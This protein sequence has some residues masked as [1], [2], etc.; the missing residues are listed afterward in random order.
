M[1]R[2]LPLL[3]LLMASP[4]DPPPPVPIRE[5]AVVAF[6]V[7]TFEFRLADVSAPVLVTVRTTPSAP[8]G[9]AEI[10]GL[11]ISLDKASISVGHE[12]LSDI[13]DPDL[14]RLSAT[15]VVT[16]ERTVIV[17]YLLDDAAGCAKRAAPA[18]GVV[19][20]DWTVGEGVRKIDQRRRK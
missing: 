18:C 20:L 11:Q 3:L 10:A 12:L 7:A 5:T 4:A 16:R 14:M 19:E 8:G 17:L 2:A 13:P 9:R 15:A 1:M 6:A